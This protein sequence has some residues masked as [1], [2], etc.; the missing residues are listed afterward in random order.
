MAAQPS[1]NPVLPAQAPVAPAEP[2]RPTADALFVIFV[3]ATLTMTGLIAGLGA[4]DRWWLLAPVML[5]D[6]GAA[7]AILAAITRL[8]GDDGE[9]DD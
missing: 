3:V 2:W 5:L 1:P 8:L 7:A 4:L 9:S 6:L